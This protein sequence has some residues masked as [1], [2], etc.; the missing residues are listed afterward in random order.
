VNFLIS[1]PWPSMA[2]TPRGRRGEARELGI[3]RVASRVARGMT[4]SPVVGVSTKSTTHAPSLFHPTKSPPPPRLLLPPPTATS[5]SVLS[6]PHPRAVSSPRVTPSP[7]AGPRTR[8]HLLALRGSRQERGGFTTGRPSPSPVVP[9]ATPS[10]PS[11]RD[12]RG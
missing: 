9:L 7:L 6:H 3:P 11:T 10:I 12:S 4:W 1:P 2:G 5:V 8:R